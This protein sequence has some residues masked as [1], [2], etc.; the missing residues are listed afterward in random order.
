MN[1]KPH[2]ALRTGGVLIDIH[3]TNTPFCQLRVVDNR[4]WIKYSFIK[5]FE[6]YAGEGRT[7]F[8]RHVKKQKSLELQGFF[9]GVKLCLVGIFDVLRIGQN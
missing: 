5:R 4:D 9:T 1:A 6:S 3:Y 2:R 8:E 7:I